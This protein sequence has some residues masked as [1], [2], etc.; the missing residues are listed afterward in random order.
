MGI[1]MVKGF[2]LFFLLFVTNIQQGHCGFL[3]DL[4]HFVAAFFGNFESFENSKQAMS[5]IGTDPRIW[6]SGTYKGKTTISRRG[7]GYIR[8]KL[9][10]CAVTAKKWNPQCAQLYNRLR[11]KGMAAKPALVAVVNKLIRQ[12]FGVL[13]SGKPFDPAFVKNR[14]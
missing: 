12:S 4:L 10:V 5:Y 14:L 9:Y 2:I 6:E 3:T 13:K 8:K 11:D 7:D 1:L